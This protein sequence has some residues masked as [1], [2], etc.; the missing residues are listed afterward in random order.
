M[1]HIEKD[2]MVTTSPADEFVEGLGLFDNIGKLDSFLVKFVRILQKSKNIHKWM[3]DYHSL[4]LRLKLCGF[5]K[6]NQRKYLDSQIEDIYI[7]LIIWID[8]NIVFVK[9]T[10]E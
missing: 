7:S 2:N 8:S 1:E 5:V 9:A 3:Y 4:N 6:I 10:G